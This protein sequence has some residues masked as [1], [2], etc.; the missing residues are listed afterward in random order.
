MLNDIL[1]IWEG[2]LIYGFSNKRKV[3]SKDSMFRKFT[4]SLLMKKL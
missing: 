3:K 1:C 2:V 4:R